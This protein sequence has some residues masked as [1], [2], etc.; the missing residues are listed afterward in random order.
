L[1]FAWWADSSRK[2]EAVPRANECD[3]SPRAADPNW[4]KNFTPGA[5]VCFRRRRRADFR[6]VERAQRLIGRWKA[7]TATGREPRLPRLDSV[8]VPSHYGIPSPALVQP[9]CE[10]RST[11]Y[12]YSPPIQNFTDTLPG[13]ESQREHYP[14]QYRAFNRGLYPGGHSGQNSLQDAFNS[15]ADDFYDLTESRYT[16]A[17]HSGMPPTCSAVIR[18]R[19]APGRP[20]KRMPP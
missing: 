1:P 13:L 19:W 6:H 10:L 16:Q 18:R 5:E 11:L 4:L 8:L 3:Q 17:L 12:A 7:S 14:E 2:K 9:V 20:D 15:S